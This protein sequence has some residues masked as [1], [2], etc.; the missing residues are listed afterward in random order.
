MVLHGNVDRLRTLL[1]ID[2]RQ[3]VGVH[4]VRDHLRPDLQEVLEPREA[5]AVAAPDALVPVPGWRW[6]EVAAVAPSQRATT[7][8][9]RVRSL[10]RRLKASRTPKE[11]SRR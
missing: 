9:G 6:I 4:V 5:V 8:P 1:G 10:S 3:V 2:R 7:S 11:I